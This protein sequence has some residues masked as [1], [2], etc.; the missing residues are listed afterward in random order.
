[1]SKAAASN[2]S[3]LLVPTRRPSVREVSYA[4]DGHTLSA[5]GTRL[6]YYTIGERKPALVCCDGLGCDG[7]VW[8]YI[9]QELSPQHEVLRWHY[10]GHGTSDKPAD[11]S[12]MRIQDLVEDLLAVLDANRIDKAVLL[13]HSLGV[14]V[15]LE[16]HRRH[17]DRVEALIPICGSYGKPIDTFRDGPVMKAVFPVVS[18]LVNRFPET[19]TKL[20]KI[21]DSELSFQV[22]LRTEVN[23]DLVKREDFRPYLT[24]IANVDPQLFVT[25]LED[26]GKHDALPH[27][28]DID[29]PTLIIAGE[30]DNFTPAWL[31]QVMHSRVRESELCVVPGGTHTAPIEVP[32]L[33]TL[34]I[35][36]FLQDR[37][38]INQ[39]PAAT[40]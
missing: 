7:Y 20:W 29:V 26:A 12:R 19:A 30:R 9:A 40:G 23:G 17:P 32:E 18:K 21:L 37:V 2:A 24:H 5:D 15:I 38:L 6:H 33:V 35:Q 3:P 36:R 39:A 28:D 16:A 13:G 31:S 11:R 34:R 10:R 27:L 14:Q 1:M 4:V 25:L 22:A 8:K